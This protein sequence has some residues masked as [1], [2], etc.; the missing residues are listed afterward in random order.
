MQ[1]INKKRKRSFVCVL[2]NVQPKKKI[3]NKNKKRILTSLGKY[4][5]ILQGRR[6]GKVLNF[7]VF[8]EVLMLIIETLMNLRGKVEGEGVGGAG[9]M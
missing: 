2:C 4:L 6:R 9:D 3:E 1:L 5:I 8:R 7:C